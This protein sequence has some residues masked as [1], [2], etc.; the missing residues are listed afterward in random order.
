M[1]KTAKILTIFYASIFTI[2]ALLSG[3]ESADGIRGF[4]L[5]IPNVIPWLLV[6]VVVFIAWKNPRVGGW[7]FL[8]LTATSVLFFNTYKEPFLFLLI[9]FPLLVIGV[10]FLIKKS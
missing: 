10:L 2:F 4:L 8:L 5:N 6:W 1:Q 9:S 7:L 3:A